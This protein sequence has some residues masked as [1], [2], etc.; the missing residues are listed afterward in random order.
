MLGNAHVN[1]TVKNVKEILKGTY[2]DFITHV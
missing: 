2:I 1:K